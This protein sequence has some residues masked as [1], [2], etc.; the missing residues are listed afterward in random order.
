MKINLNVLE[1]IKSDLNYIFETAVKKGQREVLTEKMILD[2]VIDSIKFKIIVDKW[3]IEQCMA[4]DTHKI[5]ISYD[6]KSSELI[7]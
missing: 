6:G 1:D 4:G 2:Y 3:F 7:K 5:A